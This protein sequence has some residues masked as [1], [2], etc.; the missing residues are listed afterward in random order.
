MLAGA[1]RFHRR[2][3]REDVGLERDAV[4]HTNDVGDLL[5]A[6]V[7]ALHGPHHLAH[8]VAALGGEFAGA[9]RKLIGLAG[10]VGVLPHGGTQLLHR[11]GGLL[12]CRGLLFGARAQ[13]V[14]AL[15]DLRAGGGHALGVLAHHAHHRRELALH[16]L[17][18]LQQLRNLVGTPV[19]DLCGQIAFG[20]LARQVHR[21]VDR[22]GDAA[23]EQHAAGDAHCTHQRHQRQA[24]G[25]GAGGAGLGRLGQRRAVV[26]DLFHRCVQQPRG[27]AVHAAHRLVAHGVVKA[28][29]LERLERGAVVLPHGEVG[30][31]E[32]FH[33]V[34]R[35]AGRQRLH[36][37][38]RS[39]RHLA[40]DLVEGAPV[41]VEL[42][43]VLAAQE[44]VFPFL[45]LRLELAEQV[46]GRSGVLVALVDLGLEGRDGPVEAVDAEQRRCNDQGERGGESQREFEC[47]FHGGGCPPGPAVAPG[48]VQT[49]GGMTCLVL[50]S[51]A[52]PD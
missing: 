13:V 52:L 21:A 23:A 20:H 6:V 27:F 10:V 28:R 16:G 18:G 8:H 17:H 33:Q 15:G 42:G 49:K 38:F 24:D 37:L 4:D 1:G 47:E 45:H 3:E 11:R 35:L 19:V 14:V 39:V 12:Q 40:F 7:D 29:G 32:L 2:V 46:A 25:G 43:R 5:A 36:Q 44:G 31:G 51:A 9:L 48:G 26:G 22:V 30:G 34:L 41:A 50:S